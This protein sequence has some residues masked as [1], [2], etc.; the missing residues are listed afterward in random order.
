MDDY[1]RTLFG[2]EGRVAIVTGGTGTLGSVM[3]SGLAAAGARVGVL[4]RRLDRAEELAAEIVR[5]GGEAIALRADVLDQAE[6]DAARDRILAEWGG[7]DILV[8]AAGGNL[9]NATTSPELSF[10]DLPSGALEQVIDLN[11]LGTLLPCQ[12][13]G[14]WM[15]QRP[16]PEGSIVTISSLSAQRALSRVV[17]YGAA[18]AAVEQL[19]R[20]LAAELARRYGSGL[21]VNAIAPGFFLSDQNRDLLLRP[22]GTSSERGAAIAA[23]TPAGRFGKPEE[24]IGTLIWLCSPGAT[25]VNGAVIIVDGGF[26]AF[27]G[28]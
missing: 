10:F 20:W 1:L 18:K 22:D 27:S 24:L 25:F 26:N 13:F 23:H 4:G 14:R 12:V 7:I 21:R 15:A 2:L 3:A 19:T 5:T 6:L 16:K 11:L 28:V 17:G 9:P 8:N